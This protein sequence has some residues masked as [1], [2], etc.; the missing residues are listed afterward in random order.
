MINTKQRKQNDRLTEKHKI[1]VK[2]A[3]IFMRAAKL[4]L[5][6]YKS[7]G[8]FICRVVD[9]NGKVASISSRPT[10]ESAVT[11]ALRSIWI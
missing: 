7:E 9:K 11:I 5:Y 4:R 10:L 3:I 6:A 1:S 8:R 2:Q